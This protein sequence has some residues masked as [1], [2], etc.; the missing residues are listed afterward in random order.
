MRARGDV[1]KRGTVKRRSVEQEDFV[2]SVYPEGRRSP[3]SGAHD[4]IDVFTVQSGIEC[5]FEGGPGGKEVYSYRVKLSD[6]EKVVDAAGKTGRDGALAVRLYA[7][8]SPLAGAEGNVD[9]V[10]RVLSDDAS[11][12]TQRLEA[13]YSRFGL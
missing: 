6:L 13:A 3:S 2:A 4:E 11:R 12:E 8:E 1:A 10:V 9:L 5:K 7:P